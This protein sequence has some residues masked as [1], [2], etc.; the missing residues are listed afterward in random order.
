ML[1][2][3]SKRAGYARASVA[4]LQQWGKK[5]LLAKILHIIGLGL[6]FS[7]TDIWWILNKR[8]RLIAD[9]IVEDFSNKPNK[10]YFYMTENDLKKRLLLEYFGVEVI[11]YTVNDSNYEEVYNKAIKT[12]IDRSKE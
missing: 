3:Y 2:E 8:K 6:D 7:E 9:R 5:I 10:I 1:W 4:E 12:V 11:E